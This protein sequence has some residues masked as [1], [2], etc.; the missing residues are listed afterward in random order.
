MNIDEFKI[1][2]E[3]LGVDVSL[4]KLD[5]LEKYFILL[6]E[7]NKKINL[8]AITDKKDVYLKH[9]YDSL[10]ICKVIDLNKENSFCDIG[11]GAG[12]PGIVIKIFFPHLKMTLIDSLNKRINFLG[13]VCE[14]LNL[15][16]VSLIHGRAEEFARE[17][18]D[19]FDVVTARAV[20]SFN[21]LLEYSIPIV[22]TNKYFI[23]MRG[24]DDSESGVN[25]LKVLNSKVLKKECFNLPYE[26]SSRCVILVKKMGIVSL[27][28]PR[29]F[30]EIKKNSL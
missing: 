17:N 28:Y 11:T 6:T 5:L 14:E 22:K 2:V 30:S 21:V 29:K 27:K 25:A 19:M 16:D 13:V 9:F 1:E 15:K 4:E 26:N 8:T 23:A 20:S 24:N 7:W 12:F 3:K 10:T 18:R